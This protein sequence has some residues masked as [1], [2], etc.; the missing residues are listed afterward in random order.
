MAANPITIQT[1]TPI[2]PDNNLMTMPYDSP[3]IDTSLLTNLSNT[4][5]P[6]DVPANDDQ[7]PS[8]A[9]T[10]TSTQPFP[11]TDSL[12][13]S[14]I[15]PND[16]QELQKNTSIQSTG[17]QQMVSTLG[18]EPY[19]ERSF[20]LVGFSTPYRF[21]LSNMGGK[22]N[23][24][25]K[26]GPGWIFSITNQTVVTDFLDSVSKGEIEP[27]NAPPK[28]RNNYKTQGYK[29]QGYQNQGYQNQGYQNSVHSGGLSLPSINNSQYSNI[30]NGTLHYT[31]PKQGM[32][33]TI[34]AVN[35]QGVYQI[36][37]TQSNNKKHTIDYAIISAD[38]GTTS[39]AV[40]LWYDRID[41][42]LK[43]KVD[44]YDIAHSVYFR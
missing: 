35:T 24:N 5:I 25:L 6:M 28:G 13:S 14:I 43:W 1:D 2:S 4:V 10:V 36:L 42:K 18:I 22:W 21:Y 44:G 37:Q 27:N 15:I 40:V 26:G 30:R 32:T 20:K 41:G 39:S 29:N 7:I 31:I 33:V 11:D 16:N 9:V 34:K 19:N 23:K 17:T 38:N 8:M 12:N 3:T